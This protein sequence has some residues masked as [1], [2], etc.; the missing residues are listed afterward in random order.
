MQKN[1]KMSKKLRV[2]TYLFIVKSMIVAV[3][4]HHKHGLGATNDDD[5]Y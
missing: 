1:L 3:F 5:V 2:K 4:Y